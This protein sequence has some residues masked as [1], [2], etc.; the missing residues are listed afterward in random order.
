MTMKSKK[1]PNLPGKQVRDRAA[2]IESVEGCD[3]VIT[4]QERA[5][6]DRLRRDPSPGLKISLGDLIAWKLEE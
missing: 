1:K 3:T 4:K 2:M 5:E 6:V